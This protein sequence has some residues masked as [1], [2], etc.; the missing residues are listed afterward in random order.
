MTQSTAVKALYKF[1]SSF[2][3]PAYEQNSVPKNAALP[4]ITYPIITTEWDGATVISFR[5]WDRCDSIADRLMRTV[6]VISDTIG[7][8]T[9]V[10]T[11]DGQIAIYKGSPFVQLLSDSDR[12]VKYAYI[13][14]E[15]GTI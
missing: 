9:S 15:V 8:G 4:Y 6:D 2:G 10:P 14:I 12:A 11:S 1:F 7:E 13:N 5:L 3:V